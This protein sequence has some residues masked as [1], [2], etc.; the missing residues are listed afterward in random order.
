[1]VGELG[2]PLPL[3]AGDEL[4]QLAIETRNLAHIAGL[5]LALERNSNQLVV[6]PLVSSDNNVVGVLAVS[7]LPFF[8][9]NVENLQMMSVI[10]AYYA[11]CIAAAPVAS[12]I[13]Q[14]L[15]DIPPMYA[16][17]VGRLMHMQNSFNISSHIVVLIFRGQ[18]RL[19]MPS[20]LMRIKRGLDL[21]WET[22]VEGDP[23]IIVLM[24]FASVSAKEGF[25]ERINGWLKSR[26]GAS[27]EM[28]NVD[29]RSINFASGDPLEALVGMLRK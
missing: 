17:E 10:L 4:F 2:E 29:I 27:F 19:E 6:A 25:L 28:I 8:S 5:D 26:F 15:P 12:A 9:L 13:G 22:M 14:R 3:K 21:Y 23:A 16:E 7:K 11:D 20:E 18:R 24:P 1:M